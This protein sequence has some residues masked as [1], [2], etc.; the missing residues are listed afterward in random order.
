MPALTGVTSLFKKG[1]VKNENQPK[2]ETLSD[3]N[4]EYRA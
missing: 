3:A 4:C 1:N 2:T